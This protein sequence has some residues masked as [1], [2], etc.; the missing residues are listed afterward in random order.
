MSLLYAM[1]QQY[2]LLLYICTRSEVRRICMSPP[3][4][5]SYLRD[6]L[7]ALHSGVAVGVGVV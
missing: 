7:T 1:H 2:K 5:G 6:C 4:K 3:K